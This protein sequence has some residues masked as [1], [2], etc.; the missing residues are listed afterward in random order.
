MPNGVWLI[1]DGQTRLVLDDKS[2][3][4]IP[5]GIVLSPDEKRLYLTAFSRIWRYEV[6]QNGSLGERSLFA[7]GPGIGDGMKVDKAG[8]VY[9]TSGGGP[10][11][12]RI[13]SVA[14]RL[15]G[16]IN[17]PIHGGEPKKQICAT[18]V[19]FGG[20]DNREMFIT[21]CDAVYR[22]RLRVAGAR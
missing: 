2:L 5:N 8:N 22:I 18:N 10:G 11:I 3:G 19:A 6:R 17:L 14:G 21:A 7:D 9:S 15:L 1:R 20:P 16:L 12:I 13:T 4:G